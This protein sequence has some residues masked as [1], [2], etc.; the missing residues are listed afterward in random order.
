MS[1]VRSDVR[2]IVERLSFKAI[3]FDEAK[4]FDAFSRTLVE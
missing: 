1:A 4:V 2:K 3:R